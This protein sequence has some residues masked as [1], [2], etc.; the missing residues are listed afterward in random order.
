MNPQQNPVANSLARAISCVALFSIAALALR[1]PAAA[2]SNSTPQKGTIHV[3]TN[4]VNVLTSVQDADGHPL[5]ELPKESFQI[6]EEGVPQEI[7]RFEAET[8]QP[9]DLALMMDTSLST[10]KELKFETETAAHFIHQV[11]RPTDRL[12]V[13]EFS[14]EVTQLSTFSSDINYLQS[15]ARRMTAG[16]GTVL[17]DSLV[18]GSRAFDRLTRDRRRVIVLVTDAG[19]TT[20]SSKFDEARRAAISSGALLYSIVV[21]PVPNESG[22][23][24]AGE[25]ALITI[26]DSTGGALFYLDTFDQLEGLFDRI[27]RELRTQYLLSYY[28]TPQPPPNVYRHIELRV[29]GGTPLHYRKEYL[30]IGYVK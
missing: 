9:L 22:R 18:L 19:E 2:Q 16:S 20:S 12:S 13:F 17:Y 7:T 25:H 15:A 8:S 21:R 28:P 4:L 1:I 3:Q 10:T 23:N 30:S 5:L 26:T 11:V 14:D 27:N 6:L 29:K 24:T